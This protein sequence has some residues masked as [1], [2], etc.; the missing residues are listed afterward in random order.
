M[1]GSMEKG[2]FVSPPYHL[3]SNGETENA[4]KN[5]KIALPKMHFEN[6]LYACYYTGISP[7]ELM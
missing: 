4:V 2:I 6:N 3:Q 5:V 7:S 1:Y